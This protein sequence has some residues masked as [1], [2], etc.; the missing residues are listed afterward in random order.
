MYQNEVSSCLKQAACDTSFSL[1]QLVASAAQN[2][3]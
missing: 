2:W 1:T 3:F